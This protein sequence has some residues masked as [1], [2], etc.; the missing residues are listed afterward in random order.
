MPIPNLEQLIG[1]GGEL[2]GDGSGQNRGTAN[3]LQNAQEQEL[4]TENSQKCPHPSSYPGHSERT[5]SRWK[6]AQRKLAAQGFA[7]LPE[8]LKQVEEKE[9]WQAKLSALVAATTTAT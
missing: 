5:Q 7:T 6:L 1:F 4:R 2:E 8:F 9:Q 3:V